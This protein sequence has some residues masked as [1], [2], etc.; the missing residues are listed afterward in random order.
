M[1]GDDAGRRLI[2]LSLPFTAFGLLW[3]LA[4]PITEPLGAH[5]ATARALG[6][7]LAGLG[8]A[9][10]GFGIYLIRRGEDRI[11]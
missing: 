11:V 1:R 6:G 2:Y 8:L 7:L 5:E 3:L 4:P 9:A 10:I